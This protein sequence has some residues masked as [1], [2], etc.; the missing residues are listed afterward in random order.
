MPLDDESTKLTTFLTPWGA[1]RFKR[2]VMGLVSAGDEH[3]RRG[4]EALLGI[5]NVAKIV[6]DV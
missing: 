1:F 6:E 4:D 5:D 3:N 2:N